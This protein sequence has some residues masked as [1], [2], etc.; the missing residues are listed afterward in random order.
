M[1]QSVRRLT[2]CAVLTALSLALSAA[3]SLVP[4]VVLIP[5]PGL[6]LGLANLVT[7]YALCRLGKRD[8]FLIVL[9]RCILG[10]LL[11]GNLSA[12]AFSLSGGLLALLSMS[13]LL[14]LGGLSLFGVSIA[15]AAAHNTG[16]II[17]AIFVLGTAAPLVYLPALLLASILTGAVT[18]AVSILLVSRVP[19]A[20]DN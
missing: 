2:R 13:L 7:V 4:I 20:L 17:A 8:A 3:E 9:V 11:G 14:P 6:R 10:A 19:K 16:Q 15:G 1:S 12:L 18:G 5:L